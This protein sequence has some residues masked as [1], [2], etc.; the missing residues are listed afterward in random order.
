VSQTFVMRKDGYSDGWSPPG[1]DWSNGDVNGNISSACAVVSSG[2]STLDL[3]AR[4]A[5]GHLVHKSFVV[6]WVDGFLDL[7]LPIPDEPSAVI[8]GARIHVFA[9]NPDGSIWHAHLPR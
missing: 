7:G 9:R 6:G 4:G 3:F 5:N 8:A 2:G 1:T